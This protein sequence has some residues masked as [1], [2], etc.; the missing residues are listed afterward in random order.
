MEILGLSCAQPWEHDFPLYLRLVTGRTMRPTERPEPSIYIGPRVLRPW[1]RFIARVLDIVVAGLL[2]GWVMVRANPFWITGNG[3]A[4]LFFFAIVLWIPAEAFLLSRWGSSPGKAVLNITVRAQSGHPLP[5]KRGLLRSVFVWAGGLTVGAPIVLYSNG[6][7]PMV[8]LLVGVPAL[9]A[10]YWQ[11][12]RGG[13]VVWDRMLGVSVAYG[14]LNGRR[15]LAV[16]LILAFG[17]IM[18][19]E[20]RMAAR[21]EASRRVWEALRGARISPSQHPE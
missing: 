13:D 1:L 8:W 19:E 17:A 11:L 18:V 3:M 16:F 2:F 10:A 7:V 5:Y 4:P 20:M 6:A 9:F 15:V 21:D 14:P 12:I